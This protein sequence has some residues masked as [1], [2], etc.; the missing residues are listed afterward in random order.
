ML[1]IRL[2]PNR[3]SASQLAAWWQGKGSLWEVEP[4]AFLENLANNPVGPPTCITNPVAALCLVTIGSEGNLETIDLGALIVRSDAALRQRERWC[5]ERFDVAEVWQSGELIDD[6][7][8]KVVQTERRHWESSSHFV[9]YVGRVMRSIVVDWHRRS[10]TQYHTVSLWD[11]EADL[12]QMVIQ[13]SGSDS[14][15]LKQALQLLATQ[16]PLMARAVDLRFSHNMGMEE[17][18]KALGLPKRSFE[19]RWKAMRVWM[20]KQL[21]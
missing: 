18:A 19:R 3:E 2:V 12:D 9:R 6:S 14:E 15:D 10:K 17:I 7:Y 21:A 4:E 5:L 16:Q 11:C 8:L 20:R 1:P 13:R